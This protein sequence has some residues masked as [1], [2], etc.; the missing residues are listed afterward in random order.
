MEGLN[1]FDL[2]RFA[3]HDGPGIRTVVFLKGCPLDCIWCHNPESK[4]TKPQ[5]AYLPQKCIGCR[6]CE[7]ECPAG[8]HTF[9]VSGQHTVSFQKCTGCG[10][11]V[12]TCPNMALKVFGKRMFPE[13][14][15]RIVA[16]DKDFYIRSKGGLTVS[17]GEPMLQ[18][19]GLRE[20]LKLVKEEGIHVCLDTSGYAPSEQYREI[21]E[22]VDSFLYDYKLTDTDDHKKFTGVG[23]SLVL[24]NLALLDSLGKEIILRCPIIPGINTYTSHYKAIAE[25]S[26]R[27][28]AVKE[29]NIMAYHN[30][31]K[32]KAEQIGSSYA[33]PETRTIEEKEKRMIYEALEACGCRKLSAG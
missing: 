6:A 7:M 2:Q 11:C 26:N 13:E 33:L 3:L 18:F 1:V 32:G 8:V 20:L 5:L 27:Y 30:M 17:G 31:A 12:T 14:I 15:M 29:V 24:K 4:S 9:T 28:K 23:N 25:I 16:R 19:V 10:K 22:Y 21:A